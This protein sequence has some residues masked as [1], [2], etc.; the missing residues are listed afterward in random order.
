MTKQLFHILVIDDDDVI[1]EKIKRMLPVHKYEIVEASSVNEAKKIL[2]ASHY[3]FVLLDYLLEDA[4]GMSLLP[5]IHT[6][7]SK[8]TPVVMITN[9]E[10]EKLVVDA[11]R[12]GAYDYICKTR[13]SSETLLKVI[14]NGLEWS[15]VQL[16]LVETQRRLEYLS[17]YDSLTGLANRQLFHDRLEHAIQISNRDKSQFTVLMMDLNL[18]KQVNDTYGHAAGD[19]LL[20]QVARRLKAIARESDTYA[21]LGGDEFAGI[22][23][24]MRSEED[25]LMVV[26]K[27]KNSIAT[28]FAL[29]NQTVEVSVSIGMAMFNAERHLNAT[30]LMA[31]ADNTMYESKKGSKL[32]S[33]KL[34]NL[35]V[36]PNKTANL[37]Q[38]LR[39]AVDNNLITMEY[40]PIINID[41]GECTGVEALARWKNVAQEAVSPKVIFSI[42]E[43]SKMIED[44]TFQ[45]IELNLKQLMLWKKQQFSVPV[46]I[47]V[48][49]IVIE[50]PTFIA[51]L[52]R[53]LK[54]YAVDA[55]LITLEITNAICN[56]HPQ[57]MFSQ[58]I[59]AKK[60]GCHI[61]F[62]DFDLRYLTLL[63]SNDLAIDAFKLDA[64]FIKELTS[65][66]KNQSI[67]D[68]IIT[69]S[70]ELDIALVAKGVEDKDKLNMVSNGSFQMAQGFWIAKPMAADMVPNW[71][72]NK[73][74]SF[75]TFNTKLSLVNQS[76]YH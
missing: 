31:L 43:Q 5:L 75:S 13:L 11:M 22:L 33:E 57:L 21:R 12:K 71:V 4:D 29:L 15:K 26:E 53:L 64:L 44:I 3:D 37:E 51:M 61:A 19:E 49:N 41:T 34:S 56:K 73:D 17:M 23:Y 18:F 72:K 65:K 58:L 40:Q 16:Q 32:S 42:A 25:A 30:S 68:A 59:E 70:Q 55:Q 39:M 7:Q 38:E 9:M 76:K 48:S 35:M 62:D 67:F 2:T 60:L 46:S 20:M 1:R 24:H 27:I 54:K 14:N 50:S 36:Q 52:A 28:P 47:N 6:M 63:Q 74:L 69:I 45:T 8:P 10:D 66:P